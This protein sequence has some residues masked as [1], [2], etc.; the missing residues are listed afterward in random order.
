MN[1]AIARRWPSSSPA[2]CVA[3]M[4]FID[5]TIV[6]GAIMFSMMKCGAL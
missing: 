4:P 6:S 5:A 3:M 1:S 2:D